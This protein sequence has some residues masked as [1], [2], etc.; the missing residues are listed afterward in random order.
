V[1]Y[2]NPT[3]QKLPTDEHKALEIVTILLLDGRLQYFPTSAM[4]GGTSLRAFLGHAKSTLRAAI[5]KKDQITFV[6]GNES[7]GHS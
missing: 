6:I 1:H 4:S 7:A 5:E 3:A 2:T